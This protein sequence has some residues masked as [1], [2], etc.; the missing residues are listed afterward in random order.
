MFCSARKLE[1][2]NYLLSSGWKHTLQ[3]ITSS[4]SAVWL[5]Y[6]AILVSVVIQDGL[7]I[8][9]GSVVAQTKKQEN[10]TACSV[11]N[12][13]T[14]WGVWTNP[15]RG[16]YRWP[17]PET[18]PMFRNQMCTPSWMEVLITYYC[19]IFS[20]SLFSQCISCLSL[21]FMLVIQWEVIRA[22]FFFSFFKT[23]WGVS[24]QSFVDFLDKQVHLYLNFHHL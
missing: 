10:S 12:P 3:R 24:H 7:C 13:G 14:W 9:N 5:V 17:A 1:G 20:P 18:Q 21:Y 16:A 4:E 22:C 2:N 19:I 11:G 15:V 6:G 23:R 8:G